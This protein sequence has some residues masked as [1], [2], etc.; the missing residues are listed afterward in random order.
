MHRLILF[1]ITAVAAHAAVT[2]DKAENIRAL[3]RDRKLAEAESAARTLVAGNPKEAEAHAL[4][5]ASRTAQGDGDGAV[6]AW[7][8]AVALESDNSEYHR[9]LGDAYGLVAQKAGMLGKMSL[10]KKCL[11]AY[12]KAVALEPANLD[13]RSSL[14]TVYQQAPAMMGGGIE[15]AR[16]QAA[17]IKKLDATRGRVVY[18]ILFIGEKKFAEAFAELE[19]ALESAP[20]DYSALYQFGRAAALSGDRIDR[21][22]ETLSQC[23]AQ[24]PPPGVPAHD[25]ANWRLGNLW[26]KKGDRNA[27]RAAYRAALAVT[28][29]YKPAVEALK[30]LE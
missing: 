30:K 10:G 18:A 29:D 14:V 11:A 21:G 23:L 13:A 3:L 6:K 19:Q 17:A 27:A 12:E 5:G 8:K 25:A 16:E 4:L 22:I 1:L 26:E 24:Q 28:P 15:K 7:E 2:P 20:A 9:Q